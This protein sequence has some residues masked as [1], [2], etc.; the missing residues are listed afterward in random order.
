MLL[1]RTHQ[2]RPVRRLAI[3]G[4]AALVTSALAVVPTGA[5]S[6]AGNPVAARQPV[7]RSVQ[8]IA[9][10]DVP[11]QP[12]SEADTLTEP[13]IAVSPTNPRI[14]VA[15]A[16]DSRFPGGGAAAISHAWTRDGGRTWKHA[17]VPFLTKITGG[18]WDRVSD[19]V[20][21]FGPGGDVYL[22]TIALNDGADCRSSVLVSRSTDGGAT[23]GRPVAARLT[24]DCAIFN[25]KNW[26]VV[27]GAARSPHRGRIYQFW[28]LFDGDGDSQ[29]L[30]WSDDHGRT[31]SPV[32]T[33]APLSLTGSQNSQPVILA[34]GTVVDTYLDY[35]L[36][37]R[38]VEREEGD[39]GLVQR[40]APTASAAADPNLRILA[41]RSTDGGVT[42]SEPVVVAQ[43]VGGGPEGI[44]CCLP[45]ATIDTSTGRLYAAWIGEDSSQVLVASSSSGRRWSGPRTISRGTRPGVQRVN[46]DVA[47][48]DGVLTATYATR[49]TTVATGRYWQQQVSTSRDG[50]RTFGPPLS[51]GPRF[52]T[53]YAAIARGIFPGDYIGSASSHGRVYVAWAL[54]G[55]PPVAGATFHQVL[56]GA[57]L[58]N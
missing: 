57:T 10:Q 53:K 21:A 48:S 8:Q 18:D 36:A 50:G 19:P 23:F 1:M 27:D 3:A 24:D 16:H 55:P 14:A 32:T 5:A 33:V 31:W 29:A 49:D 38:P 28:S 17:P 20:L 44:R 25:D 7:V 51:I 12:G 15:A 56:F 37:G 46:V 54:A 42:W 34:D 52:D 9:A 40:A 30:T 43:Q 41:R 11:T 13:D 2:A 47:A 39:R 45:S 4:A 58:T 26:I 35:E 6:G 22:S